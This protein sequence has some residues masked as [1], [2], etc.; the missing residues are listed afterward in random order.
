MLRS[1][2]KK[3]VIL[4]IAILAAAGMFL[5][6]TSYNY[7]QQVRSTVLE[8]NTN[9]AR[10]WAAMVEARTSAMYEHIYELLL[11]I[12]NNTGLRA[13]SPIMSAQTKRKI[14]EMMDD[15]ILV[16]SDVDAF[17]VFDTQHDFC[18]FSA[19]QSLSGMEILAM[20][21]Y[22]Y[23]NAVSAAKDFGDLT[24]EVAEIDGGAYLFKSVRLGK[25]LVGVLSNLSHYH[26]DE[27]FSVLG[28]DYACRLLIGDKSY[29]CGGDAVG[30]EL[31]EPLQAGYRRGRVYALARIAVLDARVV[32]SAR[33][34]SLTGSGSLSSVL[35]FLDSAVC[36]ILAILLLFLLRR[37]VA[38]PT[39]ALMRANQSL[40]AGDTACRLARDTAG[41]QEFEALY[42][43][44]NSM[45][46]QIVD[47][48]I[49]TYDMK[50]QEEANKLT[51]LRAQIR[52]H[53]FLNAVTTISNMTYNNSPEEIRTYISDFAKFIRYMLKVSS[54]W[55]TVE[56]ELSHIRN[57]LKMQELRFPK[58][59]RCTLDCDSAVKD[60][61]IPFLILYTLV[62]NSIKH[63]MT[64]YQPMELTIRCKR[65]ETEDFRGVCLIEEDNGDGF[66]PEV[67]QTLLAAE[68]QSLFAK[69][70][71]GL[72]NVRYTLNLIYHRS[73]LLHLSNRPEG[74]AR[75]EIWIP[76]EEEPTCSC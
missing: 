70:H 34:G 19:R 40:A 65:M 18:L 71:L 23:E 32:L 27:H 54:P 42:D 67:L 69:E 55:T 1:W 66:P 22:A 68:P 64:L 47:L 75:V 29:L 10:L 20:K 17:F 33:P 4:L 73:D 53:S 5:G 52:P 59:I 51:M 62:E 41:S 26:I 31:P 38:R 72:S 11:T 58:S 3:A 44:F 30:A 61:P 45:A 16:S 48:R 46:E 28:E 37:D 2:W 14:V 50:L 56:E 24:W 60:S 63:A 74:G 35:L 9:S 43:S 57:Y 6:W 8:E 36:V 15:K 13:D 39:R 49:E 12:Y 7:S 25:Y 21:A 76:E